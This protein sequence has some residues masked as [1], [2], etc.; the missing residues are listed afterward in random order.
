M[1]VPGHITGF[2]SIH[3]GEDPLKTGST[4][5]GIAIN[6][7]V[8]TEV[9]RGRGRIYF[10]GREMN[11]CPSREVID[12]LNVGG[13]DVI[14]RSE[15]PLGC[16]L[17][18]SG[19]CALGCAYQLGKL[20]DLGVDDLELL[21]IA[22]IS[23][24]R[25]GTGL[26][27]VIGQYFGGLTVRRRPGFPLDVKKVNIRDRDRYY[28]V[29][30]VMG[31]RDT[32]AIIEDPTW[33]ERINRIGDKLLKEMLKSPSLENF[34]KLSYIFARESGLAS[35]E[36]LSLCEDLRFSRGASQAML[37]NTL[38]VLCTEEEIEDVLSVLKNPIICRIYEGKHG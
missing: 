20:L 26:G 8:T 12:N 14:H 30:Q 24:V 31:Q 22:H 10:N 1:F 4:G 15:L 23:E 37:G 36:I 13:Y 9:K 5:A 25:C 21:K 3:R 28:I 35:E 6:L 33:I 2:F 29:I 27:D 7:G 32:K 19:G 18:I 38:F 34:M 16:G 17:G 11:L